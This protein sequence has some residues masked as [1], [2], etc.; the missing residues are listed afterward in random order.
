MIPGVFFLPRPVAS[1][2]LSASSWRSVGRRYL[3]LS[4]AAALSACTAAIE[5]GPPITDPT[6]L[7]RGAR[8]GGAHP[9][10]ARIQFGWTYG[11]DRGTV[12]GEGVGR[13]NQPDSLRLDLFTSGDVAMAVSLTPAGLSV[14]G[15]IEDIEMPPLAFMYAMAGLF[16]PGAD[17]PLGAWESGRD[18]VLAYP[19]VGGATRYFFL[20]SDRLRRVEDRQGGRTVRRVIVE[21]SGGEWPTTAE[22]RDFAGRSRARWVLGEIRTREQSYPPE[23]YEL[24][25]AR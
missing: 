20:Q 18:S 17:G 1:G 16:H 24:Y 7:E 25:G 9:G 8:S 23:I 5:S 3:A 11:D 13:Y 21:W 10:S 15:Q 14:D 4:A 2:S 12:H 6:A 22:Y 19:A